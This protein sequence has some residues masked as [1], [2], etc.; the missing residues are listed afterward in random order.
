MRALPTVDRSALPTFA[1]SAAAFSTSRPWA[2]WNPAD[3]IMYIPAVSC[4]VD[5]PVATAMFRMPLETMPMFFCDSPAPVTRDVMPVW[6]FAAM[7]THFAPTMAAAAATPRSTGAEPSRPPSSPAAAD[8]SRLA[9]ASSLESA[10]AAFDSSTDAAISAA[11]AWTSLKTLLASSSAR[12]RKTRS[13]LL[14][15]ASSQVSSAGC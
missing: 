14:K 13:V 4:W 9:A 12:S 11:L 10:I 3:S 5:V 6:N 7:S 1:P 8:S 15:G 2:P